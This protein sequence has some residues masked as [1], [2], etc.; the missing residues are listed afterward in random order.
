M[1]VP[2]LINLLS[3]HIPACPPKLVNASRGNRGMM[4]TAAWLNLRRRSPYN[5]VLNAVASKILNLLIYNKSVMDSDLNST[6]IR[7]EEKNIYLYF[8]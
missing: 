6:L 3:H 2:D 5:S 8:S 1:S 7:D 4:R